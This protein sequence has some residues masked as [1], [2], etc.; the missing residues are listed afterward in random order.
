MT[1]LDHN[2]A[3]APATELREMIAAG[4]ITSVELTELY[5]SRIERL[6]GAAELV[7][8]ADAGDCA[9]AG[10]ARGRGDCPRRKPWTASR[11]ARIAKRPSDD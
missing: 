3:F 5:L 10:A 7:P 11:S 2:L 4:Q 9:G 1:S 8:D 6:D